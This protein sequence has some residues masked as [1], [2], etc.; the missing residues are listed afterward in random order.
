MTNETVPAHLARASAEW[1]SSLIDVSGSNRLLYFKP[2]ASTIDLE[3]A[4]VGVK[5]RLL[6]GEV[7]KLS[8]LVTDEAS[9]KAAQRACASLARKQREAREEY[10]VSV[11]FLAVG[12]ASW[13]PEANPAL[14][15]AQTD[16]AEPTTSPQGKPKYTHPSAP[17]LLRPL[18]LSLKRGA[19]DVWELRLDEDFQ[20]NGVLEHVL[21]AGG[22]RFDVDEILESDDGTA[23]GLDAMLDEVSSHCNDIAEFELKDALL[24]GAFSYQK[25]TM[26][27]DI[28]NI[29]A[30]AGSDLV[31]ALSGDLSAVGR[32]RA[33]ASEVRED[34]PDYEPVESEFLVLDA[35]ASQ[36][37]IVNAAVGGRN[38]VVQ[39]PP[40]T[41]KSQT[42]ANVIAATVA[43]GRSV[44]FVAQ[45]RAAIAAVLDRLERVGL[46]HLVLDMFASTGSRR[47]VADQLRSVL[48]LQKSAAL[49][50]VEDLHLR[51]T[52]ARDRLVRHNDALRKKRGW[53]AA[54]PDGGKSVTELRAIA[55]GLPESARSDLRVP[56]KTV[57]S[58][59]STGLSRYGYL[60]DQLFDLGSLSPD[61]LQAAGWAP[62][63]IVTTDIAVSMSQLA[64]TLG[65]EDMPDVI[66]AV[67]RLSAEIG[68]PELRAWKDVDSVLK[69][70]ASVAYLTSRSP[71]V[72]DPQI[73]ARLD[74]LLFVT[75]RAYRK[76]SAVKPSWSLRRQAQRDLKRVFLK[77]PKPEAHAL[78]LRAR[79]V[80][81]DWRSDRHPFVPDGF[82]SVEEAWRR[83]TADVAKVQEFAQAIDFGALDL[84]QWEQTLLGL[85]IDARLGK[86][87][88]AYVYEEELRSAGLGRVLDGVRERLRKDAGLTS[89]PSQILEWCVV[90]SVL[91]D[92]QIAS[93]ELS[94]LSGV[95]LNATVREF[96]TAE[97]AKLGANAARVRRIAAERL[98][99]A[100]DAHSNE[101]LLLKSEVTRKRNFRAVRTLFREAPNV[102][103]AVKPVWAM[104]P[105]QVS[106]LLP[107]TE[108]FD[109]VIFDEAS[110]VKPAD[111]IP[112][113]LRGGQAVIAGDSRQLPPTD[114]FS[115]VLEDDFGQPP[116]ADDETAS[117]IGDDSAVSPP[118][119]ASESFTRDAESILFAMDR[120]LAGQSRMLQ[121]HY[122]SRDDRLIA[123]SNAGIYSGALTTFPSA[124][125]P[126]A[127]R[128]VSVPQSPGVSGT[129]NSPDLEV[130]RVVELVREHLADHKGES[131]GVITF[132]V[133]H[134]ARIEQ[135]LDQA[136]H[137]DLELRALLNGATIE[138]FFVKSIERVQGD[139]RDA[140]ILSVGYGKGDDG[141]LRYFWGPLL[142]D[143]GER[144]L[145]VAI[146]RARRR[147]TL[148]TSFTPDD[149]ADDAHPS[150]GFR[151]MH[152]FL[153]YMA[154]DGAELVGGPNREATLNPFEIDV[155]DRLTAAGLA[156]DPQVG[157]GSYR[158]D[159]AVRHPK[160]PG[161][162]VLA[163]EADG[164]AYHSGA[165]ARERDR[166][167]QMLLEA[168]GW[169]FYRI[170]STDWFNNP[171]AEVAN[172]LEAVSQALKAAA[173]EMEAELPD[174]NLGWELEASERKV[175]KPHFYPYQ[176]IG[177]YSHRLIVALVEHCRSDGVLRSADEEFA[178]VMAELGFQK[179]GSRIVAAI[180]AAQRDAR[181]AF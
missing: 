91:E 32:I 144:R 149:V 104:S 28:D 1:R 71:S 61:W 146:S 40:G 101:H 13:N 133:K 155:R 59:P 100:L 58:W 115:K 27:A 103:R 4:P 53:G 11:T 16:A 6:R 67:T 70:I 159:F 177:E 66:S 99:Q 135:A 92:A 117:L 150:P 166:L 52:Q 112:S 172:I 98:K 60:V 171:D 23:D 93:P 88:S 57:E 131:L 14:A 79:S 175:P 20:F 118:S 38:L 74:A 169:T 97:S 106:R 168:R 114:F 50:I 130:K 64:R 110:Q 96:Q 78:L 10:G 181:T 22:R 129:A 145:N 120:V 5:D 24:L 87:P 125:A 7:V 75:D 47:Y 140:I 2:N 41:G 134:Q 107:P 148:V 18:E 141:R 95:Q 89:R 25:Q 68:G 21:N 72:L 8:E 157:A 3:P 170:W 121:W 84:E 39:G 82:E 132:G 33:V 36:S 44:L 143:G 160:Y 29:G 69:L 147:M 73:L 105:L 136:A 46:D 42:I 163:I 109:L 167:R 19:Q 51:L 123:V 90:R 139:E 35:D 62:G 113:L 116:E 156:L 48:D 137:D 173:P 54:E 9:Y 56:A 158:I 176:A 37:Y 26:V 34:Q 151:L 77:L 165:I 161:R 49:P 43:A 80:K 85:A 108:C 119:V 142:K 65:Q 76:S 83:V 81:D 174:S 111:A 102:M 30:L 164:A 94:S 128:Y 162:H 179:R 15:R 63:K 154:S 55:A 122:R 86:L 126:D 138:P 12:L 17:V 152:R 180:E 124:D 31:A 127:L 178:F 45:K 153:R